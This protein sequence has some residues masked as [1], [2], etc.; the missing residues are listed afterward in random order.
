MEVTLFGFIYIIVISF[1]FLSRDTKNMVRITL[2]SMTL[3]CDN[4]IVLG[5]EGI[6]PQ[7]ISSMIFVVYSCV[8]ITDFEFF[9][10]SLRPHYVY[11]FF[12]VYL[13]LSC[14]DSFSLNLI[15]IV[16]YLM[17]AYS[18]FNVRKIIGMK[19]VEKS[20]LFVIIFVL[21]IG[22]IQ[23]LCSSM[24][25][26]KQILEPLF[27]NDNISG[28]TVQFYYNFPYLR[29]FSTFMEPSYCSSFLVGAIFYII[30]L[31]EKRVRHFKLILSVLLVELIL[32]FS[33]TGYVGFVIVLAIYLLKNSKREYFHYYFG[34][35][36]VLFLF[37][38]VFKD[39][40]L[41]DVL[42][43]KV[44]SGSAHTRNIWNEKAIESFLSNPLYGT[45]FKSVRASS[46][47]YSLLGE[48]GIIG[49]MIYSL[50]LFLLFRPVYSYRFTEESVVVKASIY[51]LLSVFICMA[52]ACP[53]HNLCTFW[54]GFYIYSISYGDNLMRELKRK[55]LIRALLK[56]GRLNTNQIARKEGAN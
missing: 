1:F 14:I 48:T 12:L 40:L 51:F 15:Q 53:D 27:F 32:T 47:L 39:S 19:F 56:S 21:V 33:T 54:F 2:I 6:G 5:E 18:L 37:F 17:C 3:Q 35:I 45:G 49:T 4:V 29:L 41:N 46:Y 20:I 52:I 22:P 10:K 25:I 43:N 38:I 8:N 42:F 44:N 9:S 34:L 30:H 36:L 11:F 50:F 26:P 7:I 16:I 55:V 24:L 31:G 13:C 28:T 23:F